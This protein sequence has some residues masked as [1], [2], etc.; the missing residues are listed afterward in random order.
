MNNKSAKFVAISCL[1][2]FSNSAQADDQTN[3]GSK[4]LNARIEK[5]SVQP[6]LLRPKAP[7][8]PKKKTPET[9]VNQGGSGLGDYSFDPDKVK[10][11]LEA[12]Q[13]KSA[14]LKQV[15]KNESKAVKY[16]S[17][18]ST[19]SSRAHPPAPSPQI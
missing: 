19:R 6:R 7:E 17:I 13:A 15:V 8:P 2:A 5:S 14:Q 9:T 1:L 12:S 18:A 16:S 4:K 10:K 11:N 3:D